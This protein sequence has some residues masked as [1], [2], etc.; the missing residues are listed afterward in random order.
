MNWVCVSGK[1]N[2]FWKI[3]WSSLRWVKSLARPKSYFSMLMAAWCL[4][5][6]L[7]YLLWY[8]SG[9]PRWHLFSISFLVHVFFLTFGSHWWICSQMVARLSSSNGIG[10]VVSVLT[11][12]NMFPVSVLISYGA[13][14]WSWMVQWLFP[15]KVTKWKVLISVG[16]L[17]LQC[18]QYNFALGRSSGMTWL[19][20]E[21]WQKAVK[22]NFWLP[23]WLLMELEEIEF[24]GSYDPS[25]IG[26]FAAQDVFT[27]LIQNL[28]GMWTF[29]FFIKMLYDNE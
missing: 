11:M 3:V 16:V 23:K 18:Q 10:V 12:P 13:Q 2:C 28:H 15:S 25:V 9:A 21:W 17:G 1:L 14:F 7:M 8:G 22:W 26:I 29:P 20:P 6:V 19:V 5:R 4:N 24:A 27:E